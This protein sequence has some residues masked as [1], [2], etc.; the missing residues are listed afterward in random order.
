MKQNGFF[1]NS[2][3]SLSLIGLG[4][5]FGCYQSST[6]V[7]SAVKEIYWYQRYL[8]YFILAWFGIKCAQRVECENDMETLNYLIK[9]K[10]ESN[11]N[12]SGENANKEDPEY[13]DDDLEEKTS[14]EKVDQEEVA[15]GKDLSTKKEELEN[16]K[17][18]LTSKKSELKK[19]QE[20]IEEKKRTV[21]VLKTDRTELSLK[22]NEERLEKER[23]GLEEENIKLKEISLNLEKLERENTKNKEEYE[24]LKK[25]LSEEVRRSVESICKVIGEEV[26]K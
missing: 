18:Q 17:K 2:A 21:D 11:G 15:L 22:Q 8:P 9:N 13:G 14:S 6:N 12:L 26:K 25:K 4:T 1:K 7:A 10:P 20:D 19:I 16:K 24:E 23:K 3:T 5:S